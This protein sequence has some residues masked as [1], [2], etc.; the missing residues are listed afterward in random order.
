[1]MRFLKNNGVNLAYEDSATGRPPIL[2]VHG[3]GFDH[4]SFS[5]Q[6]NYFTHSHRVVSVDLR[7][8]G[9]S[10]A[11]QQDYTMAAFAD[12]LA[13]LCAELGLVKPVMVGHSMGGNVVLELAAQSPH[14]PGSLVLIDSAV[15][16]SAQLLDALE[17]LAAS[18]QRPGYLDAY[19][20]VLLSLRL[21]WEERTEAMINALN[22]SQHVLASAFYHQ[23]KTFDGQRAASGCQVPIAYIGAAT[24]LSDLRRF[25]SLTPQL[26]TAK[27]LGAGHFSPVEVPDQI[28]AMLTHF[29]A[30][31]SPAELGA[32]AV[33]HASRH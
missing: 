9:M 3:C 12:D 20:K 31:F 29:I 17:G 24:S 27:T 6:T 28:N 5:Q 4:T 7:G 18:L 33:G 19:R 26:I 32:E 16:P 15:L 30:Q 14:L 22:I 13:W 2:F 25:E 23:V 1:M 8:H 11:P 21:P 10:D